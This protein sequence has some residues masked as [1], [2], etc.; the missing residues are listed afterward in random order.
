MIEVI[1]LLEAEIERIR[2]IAKDP[3]LHARAEYRK[4]EADRFQEIL[5]LLEM[6]YYDNES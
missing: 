1:E 6:E 2:K 5:D 3:T 4:A